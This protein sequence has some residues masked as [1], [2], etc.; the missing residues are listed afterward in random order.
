M[1][2]PTP[3][4]EVRRTGYWNL[5]W[6]ISRGSVADGNYKRHR[7]YATKERAEK[8]AAKLNE[9]LERNQRETAERS[10]K[11]IFEALNA[12]PLDK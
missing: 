2:A 3:L 7:F 9:E 11:G 6:E 8:Y 4:W 12:K 10:V 5:E 1:S